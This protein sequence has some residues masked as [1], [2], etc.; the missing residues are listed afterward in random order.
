[1]IVIDATDLIAGRLASNVAKKALLGEQVIIVNSE[2]AVISGKKVS[3]QNYFKE[4][5]EIGDPFKGPFWQKMPDRMLRRMIR[6]MLPYKQ[7]KGRKAFGK[8]MCY[9]GIPEKFKNNKLETIKEANVSK[10]S[11]IRYQSL[12]EISKFLGRKWKHNIQI[13]N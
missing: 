2:K 9:I 10:M 7:E 3:L 8:I 6:G 12:Q 11:N 4:R 13:N 5:Y 1:M